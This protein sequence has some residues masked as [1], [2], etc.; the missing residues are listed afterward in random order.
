MHSKA[1][2]IGELLLARD[3]GAEDEAG[4]HLAELQTLHVVLFGEY[5]VNF[6]EFKFEVL[7]LVVGEDVV[8][9]GFEALDARARVVEP[10]GFG[11]AHGRVA[12]ALVL[13][14]LELVQRALYLLQL[15]LKLAQPAHRLAQLP[16]LVAQHSAPELFQRAE[17]LGLRL[18]VEVAAF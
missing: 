9:D 10:V 15:L 11:A 2:E 4:Q 8:E 17:A 6:G 3:V 1:V 16:Q 18:G 12:D 13:A 7:V 5:L 14:G